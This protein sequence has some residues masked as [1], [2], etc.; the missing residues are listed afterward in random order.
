MIQTCI[1]CN[2]YHNF[3]CPY[4]SREIEPNCP[5]CPT[6]EKRC[7][8][9]I[10][11]FK[12]TDTSITVA[13]QYKRIEIPTRVCERCEKTVLVYVLDFSCGNCKNEYR[14]TAFS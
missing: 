4:C 6:C 7:E 12:K 2:C 11:A 10:Y 13:G 14:I 5:I 8:Y 9:D 3:R 1:S